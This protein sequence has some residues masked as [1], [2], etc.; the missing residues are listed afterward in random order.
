[1]KETYR[2]RYARMTGGRD[3]DADLAERERKG[4]SPPETWMPPPGVRHVSI[5]TRFARWIARTLV[6]AVI[7]EV[8]ERVDPPQKGTP[9][10]H[11]DVEHQQAQIRSA[12]KR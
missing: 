3:L 9:L 5:W 10:S 1:M 8:E 2:E 7:D 12:T 11:K 6:P 4:W